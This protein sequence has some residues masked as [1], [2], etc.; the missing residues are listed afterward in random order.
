MRLIRAVLGLAVVTSVAWL[1][2]GALL[3]SHAEQDR[4]EFGPVSNERYRSYLSEAILRQ[5]SSWPSLGN[6]DR[7][8]TDQLNLRLRV[9]TGGEVSIYERIAAMHAIMRALGSTYLN[10]NASRDAKP[11]SAK[12]TVRLNYQLERVRISLFSIYPRRVW[13]QAVLLDA[14]QTNAETKALIGD[15][16]IAQLDWLPDP[17]PAEDLVPA[18]NCP[19]VPSS[20][21]AAAFQ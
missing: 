2:Y 1:Q 21:E 7:S 12:G 17:A 6:E 3:E 10:V 14:T 9:L 8:M 11:Y 19:S 5:A 16:F 20:S 15:G 13:I 18:A 4:C